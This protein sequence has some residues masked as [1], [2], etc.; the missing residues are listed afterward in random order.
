[1]IRVE[2][3]LQ[4]ISSNHKKAGRKETWIQGKKKK[5]TI[6]PIG[7]PE[8]T[9][10]Q[11]IQQEDE[12]ADWLLSLQITDPELTLTSPKMYQLANLHAVI[13]GGAQIR[14]ILGYP[15]KFK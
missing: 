12:S 6:D 14:V 15:T 2:R 7:N 8:L 4:N 1:M 3:I 9:P 13:E 11:F 10:K 5:F